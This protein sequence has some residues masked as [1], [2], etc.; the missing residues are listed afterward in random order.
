MNKKLLVRLLDV[1]I[2]V[3]LLAAITQTASALT[4][5]PSAPDAGSTAGLMGLASVALVAIRRLLR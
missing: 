2:V 3:A 1:A 5:P 4:P